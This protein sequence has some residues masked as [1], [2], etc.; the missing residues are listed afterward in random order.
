MQGEFRMI[1][2]LATVAP[3]ELLF[4][5]D[6]LKAF[7]TEALR[8][9]KALVVTEDAISDAKQKRAKLNKLAENINAYRI[10]VKKQLMAQYDEDFKPKCDELVAMTKE[11]SDSISNQIKAF[12]SAEAEAK[13][14]ALHEYYDSVADDEIR[15]YL[16]WDVVYN[17]KW[18]NKTYGVESAKT[19]IDT[20]IGNVKSDLDAIRQMG[21]D[22]TAYL[23][24]YY[25]ETLDLSDVIRKQTSLTETRKRIEQMNREEAE[26]R[27]AA[28]QGEG[29][30][31]AIKQAAAE[32]VASILENE[33]VVTID[34]RVTC[35]KSQLDALGRFLRENGIQYGRVPN[36]S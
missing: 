27:K 32:S 21:G 1:T 13:V 25:Q 5:Y 20:R 10:N 23:L 35:T 11:A 6:E 15:E 7:L 4:N 9:Y 30:M 22:D 12:E 18:A 3:K 14:A 31:S 26:R 34:F 36:G 2:D 29:L 16:P 24:G 17:Q 33:A 8:D 28:E 19:E